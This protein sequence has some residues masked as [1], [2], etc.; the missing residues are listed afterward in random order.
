MRNIDYFDTF[1]L[2][3]RIPSIRILFALTSIYKL[4]MHQMD[5]KIVSLNGNLEKEIYIK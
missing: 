5:A 3:I 1:A 4:F 2:I